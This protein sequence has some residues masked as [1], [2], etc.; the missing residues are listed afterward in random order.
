MSILDSLQS[1]FGAFLN[2]FGI[3]KP[4]DVST[5]PNWRTKVA[6]QTS[7]TKKSEDMQS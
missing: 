7:V 3:S 2:A 1:A 6:E 4:K 5:V